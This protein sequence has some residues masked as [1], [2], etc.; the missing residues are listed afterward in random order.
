MWL[1]SSIEK[2]EGGRAS[3]AN[4]I[5]REARSMPYTGDTETSGHFAYQSSFLLV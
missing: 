4:N 3:V 5:C 2:E 1:K